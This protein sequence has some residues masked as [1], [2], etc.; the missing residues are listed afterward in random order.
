[1]QRPNKSWLALAF[2]CPTPASRIGGLE[3]TPHGPT[4]Y[5]DLPFYE[6]QNLC[7]FEQLAFLKGHKKAVLV[8]AYNLVKWLFDLGYTTLFTTTVNKPILN[9]AAIP[10]I[11][12]V[13][14]KKVGNIDEIYPVVGHINSDIYLVEAALFY[15]KTEA[16]SLY[17]FFKQHTIVL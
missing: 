3:K 7:Y 17:P 5:I 11:E 9:L 1:L 8:L 15:Q 14:G 12:V 10:F 16:H 13:A 2:C 4:W 6:K